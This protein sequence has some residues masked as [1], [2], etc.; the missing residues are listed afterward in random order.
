MNNHELERKSSRSCNSNNRSNNS[1]IHSKN[2]KVVG[3]KAWQRYFRVLYNKHI[4]IA[5]RR[6]LL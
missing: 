1:S 5:R 2:A 4:S 6:E 3:E